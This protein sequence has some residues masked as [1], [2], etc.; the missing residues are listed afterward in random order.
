MNVLA[1]E[2]S[3]KVLSI[4]LQ[5]DEEFREILIDAGFGHSET[6][7]PAVDALF[8][9][10]GIPPQS[11]DLVACSAGPGS[12]TGLRIGMATAKGIARG[13]DCAIKAISTL[14]LLA[15][16]REHWNGLVVPV[17]DARKKRVYA[18]A[19]RSGEQVHEDADIALDDF[20]NSLAK[21]EDILITGPDAKITEGKG[22]VI[23]DPLHASSRGRALIAMAIADYALNGS[24]P[25]DLG[26][27]YLRLSEA[28]EK[29]KIG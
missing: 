21:D 11:L 1:L 6:L 8:Q 29:S 26:P 24:D 7:M 10:A 9:L 17:M 16:G 4:A 27:T 28:E 19:F 2:S 3:G 13:A 25:S 15:S 18:A 14:P 5:N 23:I 22:G 12:F 20:L